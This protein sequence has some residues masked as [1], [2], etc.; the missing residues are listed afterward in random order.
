[1]T[2]CVNAMFELGQDRTRI[3]V[4]QR[5][6]ANRELDERSEHRRVDALTAY[7][8]DQEQRLRIVEPVHVEDVAAD[9]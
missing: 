4:P 8:G 9:R 5:Y 3:V 1:M 6:A 7:V 2:A